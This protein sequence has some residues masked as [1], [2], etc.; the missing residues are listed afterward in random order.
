MVTYTT[1]HV[2]VSRILSA[3][4]FYS[5]IDFDEQN[6]SHIIILWN[7]SVFFIN[8]KYEY[9]MKKIIEKNI[10]CYSVYSTIT[11][12]Q[13]YDLSPFVIRV[14]SSETV[15]VATHGRCVWMLCHATSIRGTVT[16]RS[17]FFYTGSSVNRFL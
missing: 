13:S 8:Y 7:K 4:C 10:L 16:W 2:V 3:L 9:S 1:M 17:V 11:Y 15:N 12:S 6:L 5:S 14:H